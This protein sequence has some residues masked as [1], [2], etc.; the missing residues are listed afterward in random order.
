MNEGTL[1]KDYLSK[2]VKNNS[3]ALKLN[4]DVKKYIFQ[5]LKNQI[6]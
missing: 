2:L 6:Y 4:D 5:I 3:Y 1:I